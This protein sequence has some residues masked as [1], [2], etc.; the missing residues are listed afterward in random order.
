MEVFPSY[1]EVL[2]LLCYIRDRKL[3]IVCKRC[4]WSNEKLT[5]LDVVE[6][7]EL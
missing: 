4:V 6:N 2:P 1:D 3:L 5:P 7:N